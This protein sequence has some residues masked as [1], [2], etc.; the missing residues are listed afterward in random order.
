MSQVLVVVPSDFTTRRTGTRVQAPAIHVSGRV[1][2]TQS[3]DGSQLVTLRSRSG[4]EFRVTTGTFFRM[5]D[6]V[7]RAEGF[8]EGRYVVRDMESQQTYFFAPLSP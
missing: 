3:Q 8:S 6:Q 1:V 7:F 4:N 5:N 2:M